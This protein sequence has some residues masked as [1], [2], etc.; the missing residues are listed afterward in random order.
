MKIEKPENLTISGHGGFIVVIDHPVT[1]VGEYAED[2]PCVSVGIWRGAGP[3]LDS[4]VVWDC[5]SL[6]EALEK[7]VAKCIKEGWAQ[8]YTTQTEYHRIREEA[9]AENAKINEEN[10]DEYYQYMYVGASMQGAEDV[11]I[12]IENLS[13]SKWATGAEYV[14]ALQRAA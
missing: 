8:L 4:F 12:N 13:L 5:D 10:F 9:I 3:L 1:E 2:A 7:V 11:Y 6:E 14:A